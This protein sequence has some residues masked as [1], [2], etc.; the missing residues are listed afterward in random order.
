MKQYRS[1]NLDRYVEAQEQN[2]AYRKYLEEAKANKAPIPWQW[3]IFPC[4]DTD[5]KLVHVDRRFIR[6]K[7]EACRYWDNP[8]LKQ[9]LY[10]VTEV[11]YQRNTND[12]FEIF[13][14]PDYLLVHSC[15]TLF[16]RISQDTFFKEVLD[17]FYG[18]VMCEYTSRHA[19]PKWKQVADMVTQRINM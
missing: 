18:G 12:A 10:E 4:F 17:K 6:N 3:Y 11:I 14:I 16:Y 9:R 1:K 8:V 19:Q 7:E 5:R 13:G 2:G 15:M